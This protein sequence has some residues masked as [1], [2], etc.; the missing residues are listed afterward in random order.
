MT[1]ILDEYGEIE[2][3][4]I[5]RKDLFE[6][7]SKI[8]LSNEYK[9]MF[10]SSW[11]KNRVLDCIND[12][13]VDSLIPNELSAA[14][15][16][17]LLKVID[18]NMRFLGVSNSIFHAVDRPWIYCFDSIAGNRGIK[19]ITFRNLISDFFTIDL[20][21]SFI[22]KFPRLYVYI[23]N[24]KVKS[25]R[26]LLITEQLSTPKI[27]VE[28]RGDVNQNNDGYHSDFFW[29]LNS[30]L[31]PANV[32][33]E[34]HSENEM[35]DLIECGINVTSGYVSLNESYMRDYKRP[36]VNKIKGNYQEYK[37]IVKIIDSYN[38]RK[39]HWFSYFHNHNV[40]IYLTWDRVRD[41]H[42][43]AADAIN[44]NNGI[45]VYW[46]LSFDGFNEIGSKV[47]TD[48]IFSYSKFGADMEK[49]VGSKYKYNIILGYPR[50]HAGYLLK[51]EAKRL[52]KKLQSHGAEKI[53]FAI[54]ENSID[55]S[56]W[57]TG[58]ELQQENYSYILEKVLATPW[59]GVIFKP[60]NARNLRERLGEVSQMLSKA[61]ATGRCFVY[62]DIGRHTTS[63]PPILA[64]LSSDIAIHGHLCA[65]TAGL[66]CVLQGIPT[67][68][69]DREGTPNSKLAELPKGKVV[70]KNW[71]ETIDAVMQHFS[72][73]EGIP[74]FGD[75]SSIIDDLDPFIDGKA[76]NRMGTYLNW[77]VLGYEQGLSKE[78]V[79]ENAAEKYRDK[80]GSDK[81]I[82]Q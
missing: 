2:R 78:V 45:S 80:W 51:E 77:L 65:G 49:D 11:K 74:G 9:N 36:V 20:I 29:M 35:K 8:M 59:L 48:V 23:R 44:D 17:Y 19:I 43:V 60:K 56:R 76:A 13:I 10:N 34:C 46:P 73:P 6:I 22:R 28:G 58:H 25:R 79:L 72:S 21:K 47:C 15:L 18:W 31:S 54:D 57:H 30:D 64:G 33:Y 66:E 71:Q 3:I 14:R 7:R 52:R 1:D 16:V 67:L 55:D 69:I 40:K 70:F 41:H 37:A 32:L 50:D 53:I 39:I 75:W 81:V 26:F 27:F 68:L 62:E 63:A 12:E 24:T 4:R 61:E 82:T 5:P 38:C 42:M